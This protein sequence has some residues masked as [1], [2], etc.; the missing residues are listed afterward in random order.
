MIKSII[1]DLDGTLLDTMDDLTN[2]VN[3]ILTKYN[4]PNKTKQQVMSYVG[5]GVKKL[6]ARCVVDNESN[7]MFETIYKDFEEY[8]LDHCDILT[9]PYEGIMDV[10]YKLKEKYKLAVISNK[11]DPAV[12]VLIDKHF[13]NIFDYVIGLRKPFNK[14]P[15]ADLLEF[16][17]S[18]MN[19]KNTEV[20]YIG[21]SEVDINFAFNASVQLLS[22][23]Y[24][25]RTKEF[26]IEHG[27]KLIASTTKDIIPM[28]EGLNESYCSGCGSELELKKLDEEGLIPYCPKCN[29]FKFPS[30]STAVSMIVVNSDESKVLLIKQYNSSRNILVAGYVNIGESLEHAVKREVKEEVGLNVVSLRFNKSEYFG[31]N[32]VLMVNFIAV[33]ENEEFSIKE[34]EVDYA[35][36]Y[37]S[38]EALDMVAPNTLAKRF[39][40]NYIE[41]K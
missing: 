25:F 11:S 28:I 16:T 7:P 2:S 36:W 10:L 12:Q 29:K 23:D 21:D 6:V 5:N 27:A 33:V 20:I 32:K 17:M 1:F 4:M 38:F 26:L 37:E 30:F 18:E 39:V 14:K 22:V 34:N 31:K 3:Y 8:Y 15:A 41:N 9:A 13:P 35:K 19:L 24:G 40:A